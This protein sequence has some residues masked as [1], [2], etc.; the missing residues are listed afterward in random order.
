[1]D[2]HPQAKL[3]TYSGSRFEERVIRSKLMVHGLPSAVCDRMIDLFQIISQT[4]AL[5]TKSYQVKE[6]GA[7]FGYRYK[8]PGIDGTTVASLYQ[9][10]YQKLKTQPSR[11]KLRKK[12][13]EYNEDDVRC[14]P[15][16]LDAIEHAWKN[17]NTEIMESSP[18][19]TQ[20]KKARPGKGTG[21]LFFR[22]S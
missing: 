7:F 15:F 19:A 14:L 20:N 12:L 18:K 16:I 3:L 2:S 13:V 21:L 6:I 5:P 10:T 9:G 1:M 11:E 17:K 8:H 22:S 4:V